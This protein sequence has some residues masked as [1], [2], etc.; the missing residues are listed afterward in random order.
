MNLLKLISSSFRYYWKRNLYVSLAVAICTAVIT[1]ALIVGDSVRHSLE[2][3]AQYRLGTTSHTITAGDSYFTQQL[4]SHLNEQGGIASSAILMLQG[5][6]ASAGGDLR[7]NKVRFWGIVQ[8]FKQATGSDY[9]DSIPAGE[10]IVS[11]NL[12]SRLN[13]EVGSFILIKIEKAGLMPK[14]TPFVADEEQFVSR[15]VKISKIADKEH[16]GRFGLQNSQTAPFN[17]FVSIDWLNELM[18]LNDRANIILINSQISKTEIDSA[19]KNSMS[20][21]DLGL[22]IKQHPDNT[23]WSIGSEKVFLKA[24]ITEEIREAFDGGSLV[25]T[26]FANSIQLH[27]KSSPYSFVSTANDAYLKYDEILI[28]SWLADDIQAKV[29]D[30]LL[31]KYFT[32]GLLRELEEHSH[33]FVVRRIIPIDSQKGDEILMPDIPGLSDTEK[34]SEWE[35]GMPINFE[36]IRDKDEAYWYTYGGTP[37]AYINVHLA[38]ELWRN[39]FGTFTS[40]LIH[41]E[42]KTKAQIESKLLH[43]FNPVSAGFVINEVKIDSLNAARNGTDFSQL[44]I[45]LSFF[46][47][48]SALLLVSLLFLFNLEHRSTQIGHFAAMGFSSAMIKKIILAE[49]FLVALLGALAG[50]FL[51]VVYN[52]LVFMA[53]SRVWQDIVRTEVLET[54][55][56]IKTLII[57]FLASLAISL[58]TLLISV[59]RLLKRNITQLQKQQAKVSTQKRKMMKWLGFSLMI[60]GLVFILIFQIINESV[61]DPGMFF[62]AGGILLIAS[63]LLTDLI[64]S[65]ISLKHSSRLN[66][67]SLSM[68]NMVRNR[69][70]SLMVIILLSIGSF[71]VITTGANRQDLYSGA[72]EKSSGT[73]GFLLMAESTLPVLKNLN[74]VSVK[75]EFGL[76]TGFQV[77]QFRKHAGDDASCL[78]LNRISKPQI[79]GFDPMQLEGRFSFVAKTNDLDDVNPWLSLN[80]NLDGL[81]PAIADQTVIQW[82]LGKKV[83][84]TLVYQNEAGK[85]IYLKL[86]GGLAGSVFQGNVLISEEHFLKNFPSSSGSNFFLIDGEPE[87]KEKIEKECR[88]AFRDLGWEMISAVEKLAEFKSVENTYLS[89]FLILGAL[90]LLL[91]TVGLA[92][93]L[94]RSIYERR[95]EIAVYVVSGYS[96]IQILKILVHEY[97]SLLVIGTLSGLISAL[98][99]VLPGLFN[100][101]LGISTWFLI[102]VIATIIVHGTIWIVGISIFQISKMKIPEA[103]RNE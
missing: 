72:N 34:C 60:L 26:Y 9:Y 55:I 74:D 77:C 71:L 78:N 66:F 95:Q 11:Q 1:G 96:K 93:V 90:G 40:I 76:E 51:A 5:S 92:I 3:S 81:I 61:P 62:A 80:K 100:K 30:T 65:G 15:R 79:L 25:L 52:D 47:I 83:G 21:K 97:F 75:K 20:L 102:I 38:A 37:K 67:N 27:D 28:N 19:L 35:T 42:G 101:N 46:L 13:L 85:E 70:R 88:L 10:A 94:A 45:G 23:Y 56:K 2:Q 32:I 54:S 103:L 87:H 49:G 16:L 8:N 50:L 57:G 36:T 7:M 29:G 44:F 59:N 98:L 63:L 69:R 89:I 41:P 22:T 43:S 53:L 84:D 48:V 33:S 39:R 31:L 18:E 12:A 99:A 17:I 91:G 64:F 14:N 4:A 82:G 73:G 86:I 58:L 68:R 6:V 24:E